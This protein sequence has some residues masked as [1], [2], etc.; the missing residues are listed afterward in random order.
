MLKGSKIGVESLLV[1]GK[2]VQDLRGVEIVGSAGY[3]GRVG[4]TQVQTAIGV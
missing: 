4:S 1:V 3:D 2:L